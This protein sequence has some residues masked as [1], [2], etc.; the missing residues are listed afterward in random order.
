MSLIRRL[1]SSRKGIYLWNLSQ[2]PILV[3]SSYLSLMLVDYSCPLLLIHRMTL[4]SL[5]AT[6]CNE[7]KSIPCYTNLTW[8]VVDTI[9]S[10]PYGEPTEL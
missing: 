1:F 5:L 9:R 8:S 6:R 2:L 7:E 10:Q 4:T 3:F